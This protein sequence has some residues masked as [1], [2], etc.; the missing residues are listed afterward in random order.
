MVC[1]RAQVTHT[2]RHATPCSLRLS[3]SD[4]RL[5]PTHPPHRLLFFEVIFDGL[6]YVAHRLVHAHPLLYQYVHK[7]HHKHTHELRLLSSLQMTPLDVLLTHTLPVLGA[8]YLVPIEAG[9]ELSIAKTYL[10]FQEFYGHAGVVHKGRN[11]GPAPWLA[12]AL[13]I[14]LRAQDH[15]RHHIKAGCNFSKRFSLFDR[16]F[17]TW[18]GGTGAGEE[19]AEAEHVHD[20]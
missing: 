19:G 13:D 16:L 4:T 6:F 17:G 20:D 1:S 14:E 2:Q 3:R 12:Y 9:I 5:A 18:D 8:L 7:L 10:L 11:F 15:Q